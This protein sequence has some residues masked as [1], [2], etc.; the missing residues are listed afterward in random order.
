MRSTTFSGTAHTTALL[1]LTTR[2]QSVNR[3]PHPWTTPEAKYTRK[4]QRT[5]VIYT[6][7]LR[8]ECSQTHQHTA[9]G[10]DGKTRHHTTHNEHCK[11]T[12]ASRN[13]TSSC[14]CTAVRAHA[15]ANIRTSATMATHKRHGLLVASE[16]RTSLTTP[17]RTLYELEPSSIAQRRNIQSLF[18][19]ARAIANKQ[20]AWLVRQTK[21]EHHNSES[22][23]KGMRSWRRDSDEVA[24]ARPRSS[25]SNMNDRPVVIHSTRSGMPDWLP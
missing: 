9:T 2:T 23:R 8:P 20:I 16:V 17:C 10:G 12:R 19:T 21:E 3:T 25:T 14:A 1:I 22:M 6:K 15:H 13:N 24:R 18:R 7:A 11:S 5:P 4:K